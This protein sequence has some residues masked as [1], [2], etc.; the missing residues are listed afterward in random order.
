MLNVVHCTFCCVLKVNR[1][2]N[3]KVDNYFLAYS[4]FGRKKGI[5]AC[6]I[7]AAFSTF[8]SVLIASKDNSSK[9]RTT[10]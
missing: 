10:Q 9:G 5:V 2:L 1:L 4:R 7:L 6:L 3:K 8:G